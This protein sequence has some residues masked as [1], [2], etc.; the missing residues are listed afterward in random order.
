MKMYFKRATQS[1]IQ[2]HTKCQTH[3]HT[4]EYFSVSQ[5][6]IHNSTQSI[7]RKQVDLLK[8]TLHCSVLYGQFFLRPHLV[9]QREHSLNYKSH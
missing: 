4:T 1:A 9:P 3:C 8:I 6:Q 2:S 7:S 5:Q